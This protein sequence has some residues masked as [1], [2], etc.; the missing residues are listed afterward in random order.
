MDPHVLAN[1]PHTSTAQSAS[2]TSGV[3]CLVYVLTRRLARGIRADL[4]FSSC[5]R[6]LGLL[7]RLL[8]VGV[9]LALRETGLKVYT[10]AIHH[11]RCKDLDS[12]VVYRFL[13]GTED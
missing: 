10:D 12:R 5:G 6:I 1:V 2:V 11:E 13:G 8:R 9:K 7:R 3:P 4:R